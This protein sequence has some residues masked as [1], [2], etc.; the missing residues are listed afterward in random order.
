MD[1]LEAG[2]LPARIGRGRARTSSREPT[3]S[4]SPARSSGEREER[5][6]ARGAAL[7]P[8]VAR[9]AARASSRSVRGPG[10]GSSTSSAVSSG[11]AGL[12]LAIRAPAIE[13]GRRGGH[14]AVQLRRVGQLPA[15]RGRPAG[16]LRHRPAH[17]QHRPRGGRGGRGRAHHGHAAGPHLRLPGRHAGARATGARARP[18]DRRGRL[19]GAR[20]RAT[21]TAT[22]VGRAR[23]PAPS[24]PSTRTSRSRRGRAARSSARTP[25]V[26]ARI[27]S[28]RNQGRAPDMGWLDHDRLGFNYRLDDLSCALGLA[29]LERLD[30]MLAERDRV[31][32][33]Y[34]RGARRA[35]R[36]STCPARTRTATGAAGSSTSCSSRRAWTA[37]PRCWRCASEA[38]TRS[39][40]CRRST[41]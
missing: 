11:T 18:L 38:W 8:A 6:G 23:Q 29:Q 26:K 15:L 20:R 36:G 24:S 7:R 28:E 35:W 3:G 4:R 25:A 31:A 39:P 1:S 40:T 27:D 17:A 16:L 2:M 13:R 10:S 33:L 19:R 34:S 14:H 5:A 22:T 12:H 9:A 37:T 30:E 21:P 41:C 32:A